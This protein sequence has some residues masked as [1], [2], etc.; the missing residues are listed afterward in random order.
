M[1][2]HT[3]HVLK[4]PVDKVQHDLEEISIQVQ[5]DLQDLVAELQFSLE[6]KTEQC[7]PKLE[8][9]N[10]QVQHQLDE[11]TTWI[12]TEMEKMVSHILYD[13]NVPADQFEHD[14]E[15]I[16][17]Q[18][19][20]DLESSLEEKAEHIKFNLDESAAEVQPELEENAAL[21]QSELGIKPTT[22]HCELLEQTKFHHFISLENFVLHKVLG[23]GSFG[24]DNL[25]FVMEYINGGDLFFHIEDKGRFDL[26]STQF[27][28]AEMTCGLQFLHRHGVIYR[29]LKLENVMLDRDGHIKIVDFG[30]S[31]DNMLGDKRALSFCGSEHYIAPEIFQGQHYF[32]PVDWWA[33]GVVIF[34]MLTGESPFYGADRDE[35][36]MSV[37]MDIP[38]YPNWINQESNDLLVKLLEK[39]PN[40][41][42]GTVGNIREHPFFKSIDWTKLEKRELEPPFKPKMVDYNDFRYFDKEFLKETPKMSQGDSSYIGPM[43]QSVFADF[44]FINSKLFSTY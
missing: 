10:E 9:E 43:D 36:C 41:R 23:K 11:T 39:D 6:E 17:I 33:F 44:S 12:E 19:Q 35:L 4:V 8:E 3:Q 2:S 42:L 26:V 25:C 27:Y 16:L 14:L 18:I 31:K 5:R 22:P 7:Q 32:S 1:E 24:K 20:R 40:H 21:I 38:Q 29:D 15:D 34:E 13:L 28:A 37:C 30:L